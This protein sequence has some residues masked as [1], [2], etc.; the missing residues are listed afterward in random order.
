MIGGLLADLAAARDPDEVKAI[1]ARAAGQ[2][3][4]AQLTEALAR[5]GF[6]VR[7]AAATGTDGAVL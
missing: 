3:N 4:E 6:A 7:M 5:A 1:L 2:D